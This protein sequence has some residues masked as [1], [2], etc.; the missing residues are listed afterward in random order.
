MNVIFYNW[1][2]PIY[3]RCWHQNDR[4][5]YTLQNVSVLL[6][7]CSVVSGI[8]NDLDIHNLY[9]N[10]TRQTRTVFSDC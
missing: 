4:S 1:V 9:S 5:W 3:F 7:Y 2:A 10:R 6:M 8:T